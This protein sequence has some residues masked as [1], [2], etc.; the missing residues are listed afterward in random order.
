[1]TNPVFAPDRMG[2]F[3]NFAGTRLPFAEAGI[4]GYDEAGNPGRF[5]TR[6]DTVVGNMAASAVR[7]AKAG[8]HVRPLQRR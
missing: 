2:F 4:N 8:N 5:L 7:G 6:K 3:G 1:M